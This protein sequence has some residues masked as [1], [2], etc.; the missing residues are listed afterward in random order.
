MTRAQVLRILDA[1]FNRAREGLRVCE[2]I[3]RF[4][5]NDKTLTL[6]LKKV[7]HAVSQSIPKVPSTLP[8]LLKSRNVRSDVGKKHS[9]LER[10]RENSL[11]LF[12]ANAQRVKESLRVLE[13]TSKFVDD[14]LWALF[15]N[16]RF[17]VYAI[18]KKI[19]PKLEAVRHHRSGGKT[20]KTA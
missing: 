11:G 20:K 1:N 6:A 14:K 17:K 15:K 13:E 16:L 7:R 12:L 5:L 8:E 2:E 19:V 9:Q 3:A 4:C 10:P 18:E